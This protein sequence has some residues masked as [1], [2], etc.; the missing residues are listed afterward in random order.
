MQ[1]NDR[2]VVPMHR[3][4]QRVKIVWR[5]GQEVVQERKRKRSKM[6]GYLRRLSVQNT[7][8]QER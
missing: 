6:F 4:D 7:L 8:P 5:N 1:G 2:N 3:S